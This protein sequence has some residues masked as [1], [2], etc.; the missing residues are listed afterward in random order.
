MSEW[1]YYYKIDP[2]YNSR[3]GNN[4]LYTPTI[5]GV[6]MCMHYDHTSEYQKASTRTDFTEELL[7]FFFERELEHLTKFQSYSW[8]PKLLHSDINERKI[9]IEFPG[10]TLND[11]LYTGRI[12]INEVPNY[13]EQIY[14]IIKDIYDAG[15]YKM[16]LYPHCFFVVDGKIKTFDFYACVSRSDPYLSKARLQGMMGN[17][18]AKRFE[19]ATEGD[20]VNFDIFFKRLL[21]THVK[22][23]NNLFPRIHERLYNEL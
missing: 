1:R 14:N 12:L 8:A 11:I 15:Y 20:K 22:W 17:D 18:S 21:S 13:E 23:P 7:G 4:M 16:S 6:E 19:E 3:V 2:E 10:E 5:N 9:H